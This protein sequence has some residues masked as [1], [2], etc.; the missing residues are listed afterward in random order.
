MIKIVTQ[1]AFKEY[2][3][4]NY[5]LYYRKPVTL[6]MS[7]LGLIMLI[8]SFLSIVGIRESGADYVIHLLLV[9]L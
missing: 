3:K 8:L 9:F 1:L 6:W 5:L 7:F 2:L 4:L